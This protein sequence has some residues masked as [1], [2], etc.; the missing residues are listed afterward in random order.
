MRQEEEEEEEEGEVG[1]NSGPLNE[2]SHSSSALSQIPR[3]NGQEN[4]FPNI[5][6]YKRHWNSERGG[7]K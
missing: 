3:A 1:E 2:G 7:V 6:I 4:R 5:Y